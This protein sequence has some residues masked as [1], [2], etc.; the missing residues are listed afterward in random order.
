MVYVGAS[1]DA[2][3]QARQ[4][5]QH[6]MSKGAVITSSWLFWEAPRDMSRRELN[7][8]IRSMDV[9]GV[10]AADTLILFTDAPSTKG[11]FYTEFGI[12][13]GWNE[14]CMTRD[15][16][17]FKNIITVGENPCPNGFFS[18]IQN[19]KTIDLFREHWA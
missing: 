11:G 14:Y 6:V 1:W 3:D 2:R 18:G 16:E 19:Y 5:A 4:I 12:A 8:C 17:R 10:I 9:G 7:A 15:P 13:L